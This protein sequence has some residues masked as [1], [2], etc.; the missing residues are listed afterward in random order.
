MGNGQPLNLTKMTSAVRSK[1]LSHSW[2]LQMLHDYFSSCHF[3][4]NDIWPMIFP[5]HFYTTLLIHLI[6]CKKQIT[7]FLSEVYEVT[8]TPV[9]SLNIQLL[10]ISVSGWSLVTPTLWGSTCVEFDPH[11]SEK[12]DKKLK[13]FWDQKLK[14]VAVLSLGPSNCQNSSGYYIVNHWLYFAHFWSN[15]PFHG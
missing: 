8:S 1:N 3:D 15:S 4:F 5:A 7:N 11:H 9:E 6:S 10:T 13:H 2:V 14:A 12:K